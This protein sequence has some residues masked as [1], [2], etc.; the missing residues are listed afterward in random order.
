[1]PQRPFV[2]FPL[3]AFE[4]F[5]LC[6]VNPGSVSRRTRQ[7]RKERE[8]WIGWSRGAALWSPWLKDLACCNLNVRSH[9]LPESLFGLRIGQC[10]R[11]GHRDFDF[12]HVSP[13]SCR[14]TVLIEVLQ[15]E[16]RNVIGDWLHGARSLRR[17]VDRAGGG[18]IGD[19]DIF[20]CSVRAAVRIPLV[21]QR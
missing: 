6:P 15:G 7:V 21:A 5:A 11:A 1:M 20:A 12:Q 9:G 2:I 4:P 8:G 10:C 17:D 3:I 16:S 14:N 13:H 19:S 18:V